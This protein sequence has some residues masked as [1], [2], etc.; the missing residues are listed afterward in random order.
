MLSVAN[1][2]LINE[3][4]AFSQSPAAIRTMIILVMRSMFFLLSHCRHLLQRGKRRQISVGRRF[5]VLVVE[6]DLTD[7]PYRAAF[8][9]RIRSC[10]EAASRKSWPAVAP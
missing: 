2:G 9:F 3:T 4:A 6:H 5:P 7:T 10:P 1:A 8:S